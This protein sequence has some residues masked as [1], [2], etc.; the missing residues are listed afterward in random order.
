MKKQR[1]QWRF[2]PTVPRNALS[3]AM[4][5]RHRCYHHHRCYH[6]HR[7]RPHRYDIIVDAV[8]ILV[9]YSEKHQRRCTSCWKRNRGPRCY[10]VISDVVVIIFF[11]LFIVLLII[12]VKKNLTCFKLIRSYFVVMIINFCLVP[13]LGFRVPGSGFR[14][15][16]S[17]SGIP[18]S[19]FGVGACGVGL[20]GRCIGMSLGWSLYSCCGSS[21]VVGWALAPLGGELCPVTGTLE[22]GGRWVGVGIFSLCLRVVFFFLWLICRV[23]GGI[24]ASP[25]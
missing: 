10:D 8:V 17:S 11:I 22:G 14:G 13:V 23:G 16:V 12:I 4:N 19:G 15:L 25:G 6:R 24:V 20:G 21:F 7:R 2:H 5:R 1:R 9:S 18:V 3:P